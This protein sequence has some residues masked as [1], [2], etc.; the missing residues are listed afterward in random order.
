MQELI[1]PLNHLVL[2]KETLWGKGAFSCETNNARAK[3]FMQKDVDIF[4]P[5][6]N[7][8]TVV[9]FSL[10]YGIV[11]LGWAVCHIVSSKMEP[12]RGDKS[13]SKHISALFS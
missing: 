1:N 10:T 7:W 4:Q 13:K 3:I 11:Y 9:F 12:S 5:H 6:R 2:M 8:E